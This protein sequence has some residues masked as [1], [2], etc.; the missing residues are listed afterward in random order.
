MPPRKEEKEEFGKTSPDSSKKKG[1][2]TN[3]YRENTF[4]PGLTHWEKEKFPKFR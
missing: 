4:T 1:G 3:S 2:P